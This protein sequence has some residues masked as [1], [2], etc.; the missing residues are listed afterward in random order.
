MM[1]IRP[2]QNKPKPTGE[3]PSG[4]SKRERERNWAR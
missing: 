4:T 1:R 3:P 2:K